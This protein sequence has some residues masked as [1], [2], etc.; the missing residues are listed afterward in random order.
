M[1][2]PRIARIPADDGQYVRQLAHDNVYIWDHVL[3]A[4]DYDT[5]NG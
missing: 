4:S 1:V 2:E 3:P 5:H